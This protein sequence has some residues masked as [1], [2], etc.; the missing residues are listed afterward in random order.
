MDVYSFNDTFGT[1]LNEAFGIVE[2]AT[3]RDSARAASRAAADAAE[4]ASDP[5]PAAPPSEPA[6]PSEESARPPRPG[7]PSRPPRR[8]RHPHP[9]RRPRHHGPRFI[10]R[11]VPVPYPV[12]T[13]VVSEIVEVPRYLYSSNKDLIMVLGAIVVILAIA[14]FLKYK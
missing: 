7:N 1:S 3:G 11:P 12:E 5:R 14:L 10:P 2:K 9:P 6:T 4:R 13:G 8:R